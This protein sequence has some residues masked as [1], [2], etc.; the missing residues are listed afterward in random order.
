[1]VVVNLSSGEGGEVTELPSK[2]FARAH[3]Y[4]ESAWANISRKRKVRSSKIS[5]FR[6]ENGHRPGRFSCKVRR[7]KI[8]GKRAR[9][10][11]GNLFLFLPLCR[12]SSTSI[13]SE[14]TRE[15]CEND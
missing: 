6:V 3:E 12:V 2:N 13:K 15:K 14:E 1:M 10:Y 7:V 5:S 11:S 4:F 9:K 8:N